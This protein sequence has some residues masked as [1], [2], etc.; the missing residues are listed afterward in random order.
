[1]HS[2]EPWKMRVEDDGHIMLQV[3]DK[4]GRLV[5]YGGTEEDL[6]RIVAC[7]NYCA[8]LTTDFLEEMPMSIKKMTENL[9][10]N[11]IHGYERK[12]PE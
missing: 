7:V 1:M 2:P 3:D 4:G 8:H 12:E 9:F 10:L 5:A 6:R 11:L